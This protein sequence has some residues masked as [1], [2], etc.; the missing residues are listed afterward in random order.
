MLSPLPHLMRGTRKYIRYYLS[1]F[2]Q[3]SA[4]EAHEN[5]SITEKAKNPLSEE[6]QKEGQEVSVTIIPESTKQ[7]QMTTKTRAN[8]TNVTVMPIKTQ[9]SFLHYNNAV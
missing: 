8:E 6:P 9:V 3:D 1:H 7:S 5:A 4:R 2:S